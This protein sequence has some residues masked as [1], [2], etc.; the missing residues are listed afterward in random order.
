M[1]RQPGAGPPRSRPRGGANRARR[2]PPPVTLRPA[3][4]REGAEDPDL[5][6]E[7]DRLT[8]GGLVQTQF[9]TSDADGASAP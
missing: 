9:N 5:G 1:V 8:F 3:L 4:A 2:A 7:S 6:G